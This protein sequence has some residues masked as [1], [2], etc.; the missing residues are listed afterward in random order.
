MIAAVEPGAIVWSV[1][2][3]GIVVWLSLLLTSTSLVGPRRVARFLLGSW[4]SR[5]FTVLA[6]GAIGWHLFCQRP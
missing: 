1:L 3:A 4:T 2:A 6:W 5:L